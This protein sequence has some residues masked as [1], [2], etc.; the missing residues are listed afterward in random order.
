MQNKVF[1][2]LSDPFIYFLSKYLLSTY[3]V[4]GHLQGAKDST[5]NKTDNSL[6]ECMP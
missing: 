2:I 5:V 6:P 3:D 4:S 1:I